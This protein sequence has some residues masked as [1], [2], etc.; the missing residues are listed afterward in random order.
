MLGAAAFTA[1]A[2]LN[3]AGYRYRRRRSG[4]HIRPFCAARQRC[5]P[6]D[7]A[8]IDAQ[9]RLYV[10]DELLARAIGVGAASL[11]AWFLAL[12]LLT[13]VLLYAGLSG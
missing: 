13:L 4:R 11:E 5:F 6:K 2:T 10:F 8:L 7:S 12:Y 9:S 3:A 1:A